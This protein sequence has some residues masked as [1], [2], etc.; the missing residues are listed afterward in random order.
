MALGTTLK[1]DIEDALANTT[2]SSVPSEELASAINS[3][4]S[5]AVYGSGALTYSGSIPSDAFK[6]NS[7]GTASGAALQ[8]A[9]AIMGYWEGTATG[10]PATPT[11]LDVVVS[12]TIVATTVG[13]E[14]NAAFL[15]IFSEVVEGS[16]GELSYKAGKLADAITS[17]VGN[18]V[19]NWSEFTA[20]PPP[21]TLPLVGAIE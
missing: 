2:D 21:V 18:I 12:G 1:D 17:A 20:G 15:A 7:S 11:T 19:V 14:L 4:L 13:P 10:V 5:G 3:Y 16:K 8:W 9:N 6:L